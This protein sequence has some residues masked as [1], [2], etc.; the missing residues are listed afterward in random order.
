MVSTVDEVRSLA[1]GG[2]RDLESLERLARSCWETGEVDYDARYCSLGYTL[3]AICTRWADVG[4]LFDGDALDK[5]LSDHLLA[6]LDATAPEASR[7]ARALRLK[8]FDLLGLNG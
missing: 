3:G 7:L 8:V 2:F 5:V 6:V 4:A 1:D